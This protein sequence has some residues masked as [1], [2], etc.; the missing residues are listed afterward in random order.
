[1]QIIIDKVKCEAKLGETLLT[2]ARKNNI[3]IP[4]LC[5]LDALA[6]QGN[7]RM[8]MVEVIEGKTKKMVASCIY[9]VTKPIEV[10][11]NSETLTKMRKT[12]VM[13]LSAR[14]PHNNTVL[15]LRQEYNLPPVTR[16]KSNDEEECILCGLC[17]RACDEMGISAISTVNR[18]INKK[19]STPFEEP[20]TVCIGCGACAHVCPTGAIKIEDIGEERIIWEKSFELLRCSNCG[21]PFITRVGFEYIKNKINTE[22]ETVCENCRKDAI[23]KKLRD[24]YGF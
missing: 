23:T 2:I 5:H 15:K 1:M 6:G 9:P 3:H 4:T 11:T 20:S 21:K 16:F 13:L 18:G 17:T 24:I 12:L 22:I 14:V 19:V 10:I 7:C 8:C